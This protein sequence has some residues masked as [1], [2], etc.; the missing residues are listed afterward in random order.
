[1]HGCGGLKIP[2]YLW[3]Y[4]DLPSLCAFDT[5]IPG[6]TTR[7]A[8][9]SGPPDACQRAKL[10]VEKIIAEVLYM[11]VCIHILYRIL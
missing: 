2:L 3:L 9:M 6:A 11:Y 8:N 10:Y 1:M 5:E 4:F 7:L